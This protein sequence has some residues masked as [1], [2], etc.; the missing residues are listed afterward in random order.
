MLSGNNSWVESHRHGW[1][2]YFV[3]AQ[4]LHPAL[5]KRSGL[6]RLAEAGQWPG[7]IRCNCPLQLVSLQ[8]ALQTGRLT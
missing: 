5:L 6:I 2:V 7:V 1:Y 3:G 8:G 4:C